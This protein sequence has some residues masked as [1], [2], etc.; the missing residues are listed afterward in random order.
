MAGLAVGSLW[1]ARILPRASARSYAGIQLA[2]AAYC[3]LLPVALLML[4]SHRGSAMVVHAS[5]FLLT[6]VIAVLVGAEFS[7]ASDLR[8]GIPQRV[9]S[10][11][12]GVD[13]IGS[14][15][16]ALLVAIVLIPLL[17]AVAASIVPGILSI[18][19]AVVAVVWRK[20]VDSAIL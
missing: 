4:Q 1:R 6:F 11:L 18:S 5:V 16:G 20:K 9:A 2:I 15:L 10:E 7:I 3:F 19:A 14:A 17:G 13:L 8:R 12:Y